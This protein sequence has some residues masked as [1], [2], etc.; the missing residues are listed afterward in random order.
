MSQRTEK[1]EPY[2]A[3]SPAAIERRAQPPKPDEFFE[4]YGRYIA[5]V[6]PGDIVATLASQIIETVDLLRTIPAERTTTGYAPGKWSIRD[7]ILHVADAERI[8][9]YRALRIARADTT[10]LASFDE[11]AYTP[12]AGANA[13]SMD[14]LL[15]ELLAVREATVELLAGLPIEAWGRR[16]TASEKT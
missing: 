13:R 12:M 7:I 8:F 15:T 11:N 2:R 9:M 14:G 10:P 16:G 1:S 5:R 3:P 4:Y 6:A